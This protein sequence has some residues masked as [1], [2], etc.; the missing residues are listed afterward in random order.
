[1]CGIAGIFDLN[2]KRDVDRHA[3]QRMSAALTH[4]GP[5]GKGEFFAPGIG[6]AHRRLAVIDFAGGVQPF[7]AQGNGG[8]LSFN[9]EIYNYP[10]L[11]REM[12]QNGISLKTR[13][14][15]EVLAEGW[16][17]AGSEY[18]QKLRGMYAISFWDPKTEQLTLARDRLGERPLYYAQTADGFLIFASEISALVAS[19]MFDAKLN[20]DAVADYFY[21]GYVPDPK[22]IYKGVHKLPP[23]TI[24]TAEREQPLRF[25]RYWR[26]VFAESKN[27]EFVDASNALLDKVDDAVRTQM[28]SDAPLGAFLSG[29]VDSSGI[30]ASMHEAGG[31]LIT[32]TVGFDEASHDERRYA[33]KIAEKFGSD[34]HEHVAELSATPLVDDIAAAFGEPFADTSALPSY[35][36][37]KLA[38]EHV[39]VALS[40]DG[41]DELFAG[42]RRYRFYL[43]EENIRKRLPFALRK[44]LFGAGGAIYPKMDWAPRPLR[45][46]TTL[47]SLAQ[48][49]PQGYAEAVAINL[50]SRA[51]SLLSRDLTKS[52]GDYHPHSVIADAMSD[53]NTDD[54][55]ACAQYADLMTWLPGRMLT[56]VDRASMA[57]SLEVRPPLL[58]HRLVE[59]AGL[60]PASFKLKDGASKRI[61]KSALEPR[62]GAEYMARPKQGFDLP[63]DAWMRAKNDN[64]LDRLRASNAWRESGA[65]NEKAVM[66]MMKSHAAGTSNCAQELWSVIMFDAFLKNAKPSL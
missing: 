57:H 47:R 60:L 48:S 65:I 64:P 43:G 2:G 23:A 31:K 16:A 17:R 66:R 6:F 54:P 28:I 3:L 40:G 36:V 26:P 42:Y 62:L 49:R 58:D 14:D 30:V 19:D 13:S 38:R 35:I 7:H 55:L 37:A 21:Y 56:K 63:L 50:P 44:A 33:K 52:I 5:D 46:K 18:V 41:G 45:M 61:L 10:E 24:L 20:P 32:C 12:S 9:G 34:H 59:W 4:R 22:A 8:V 53:A 27:L 51:S 29:G 1:M 11:A 39:K 25:E 15:T